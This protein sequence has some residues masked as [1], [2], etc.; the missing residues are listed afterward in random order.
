SPSADRPMMS[1][2]EKSP[3][4]EMVSRGYRPF[5]PKGRGSGSPSAEG[6]RGPEPAGGTPRVS[7]SLPTGVPV[8]NAAPR[9]RNRVCDPPRLMVVTNDVDPRDRRVPVLRA[10]GRRSPAPRPSAAGGCGLPELG[11]VESRHATR[12]ESRTMGRIVA[13]VYGVV[14]YAIFFVTFLYAAGFVGNLVVPKSLDA[15][16]A[17]P[18][19]TSLLI[20]LGLLGFFAVQHS[21]MARPAFKR[22]WTRIVPQPI[23]RS[24]YVLAS[25]L[26]L[27]LLFWQWRPLGGV[28]WDVQ[29]P[30]GRA[31][32]YAGFAFGWLLVLVTTFLI[33]HFDLFGLRQVWLHLRGRPYR[34][35]A[36]KTPGPYRLVR[37][38][39]YV[40]WLFAFWSTP[41]MTVTH[42]L[43]AAVTTGYIVVAIRFEERDLVDAHPEYAEYA[44]RVPMLV[45]APRR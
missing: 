30:I 23:E 3:N 14:S 9:G 20:N 12:K 28:V 7:E 10:G 24:T 44:K 5:D 16:P 31:L 1:G 18:L 39:L 8:V 40:G 45:P 36:F 13:F 35:L 19:G 21:V 6:V 4:P 2:Q 42:L 33:N 17:G 37:H 26:A 27:I 29:D 43:F 41:T 15:V 38:P 34:P 22:A 11:P 32:L 25:S